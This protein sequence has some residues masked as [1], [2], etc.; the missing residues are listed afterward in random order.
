MDPRQNPYAAPNAALERPPQPTGRRTGRVRL[1][2]AQICAV[3]L[4]AGSV[5]AALLALWEIES[6]IGSG[7]VG[8]LL[9]LTLIPLA[10]PRV[11]RWLIP[12]ALVMLAITAG[13]VFTINFNHWS[14]TDAQKPIG[15]TTVVCAAAMQLGWLPILFV[16]LRYQRMTDG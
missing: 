5:P 6:I 15:Y 8:V 11:L 7:L 13:I 12:I 4:V 1:W 14:P 10:L 2:C 16:G 3:I 9:S